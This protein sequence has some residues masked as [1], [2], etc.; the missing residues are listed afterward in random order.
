ML[1]PYW[2]CFFLLGFFKF[3]VY[4]SGL[5]LT[6]PSFEYLLYTFLSKNSPSGGGY[7]HSR[8]R[9]FGAGVN[10]IHKRASRPSAQ[11]CCASFACIMQKSAN[12]TN[13][14]R[15]SS[16]AAIISQRLVCEQSPLP[17]PS[18]PQLFHLVLELAACIINNEMIWRSD[19]G[20]WLPL[21]TS[22]HGRSGWPAVPGGC[23]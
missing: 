1:C 7:S 11:L 19:I 13:V 20:Q 8:V 23:R 22:P 17:S 3:C 5:Y 6:M 15:G 18:L 16:P 10:V 9:F 4:G 14:S 21:A 2:H 12:G